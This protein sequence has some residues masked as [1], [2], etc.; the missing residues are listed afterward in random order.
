MHLSN[1]VELLKTSFISRTLTLRLKTYPYFR[2]YAAAHKR[3]FT[4]P[5]GPFPTEK[6]YCCN[7]Y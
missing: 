4:V 6:E 7:Y 1:H 5:L 3:D 2:L